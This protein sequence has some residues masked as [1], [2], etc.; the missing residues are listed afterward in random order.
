MKYVIETIWVLLLLSLAAPCFGAGENQDLSA[1]AIKTKDL[2][3]AAHAYVLDHSDDMAAVQKAFQFDPAFFDR[4]RQLYIFMHCY[5]AA[6]KEAVCCAQGVRPELVGKNMWSLRTPN[7]RLL[8]YEFTELAERYGEGWLEYDW[9]N[10]FTK[11]IQTKR[12]YV[13]KIVLKDGRK[14]WV[15]CGFW[16]ES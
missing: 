6:K 14:A 11:K 7:G 9:L 1:L 15:G 16:K 12:S 13:K 2:V 5:N 8:F 3:E 4:D 10:P